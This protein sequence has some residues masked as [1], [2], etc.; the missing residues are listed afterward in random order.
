MAFKTILL[1]GDP[2]RKEGKAGGTITPGQLIK[3]NSS[4]LLIVHAQAGGPAQAWFATEDA[5]QGN[6]I[7]DDYSSGN[8]VQF[9]AARPGDE[10]YAIL[11]TS[12][13]VAIGDLLESAGNGNLR[14]HGGNMESGDCILAVAR[15]AVTTTGAVARIVV[16]II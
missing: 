3:E 11:A 14:K 2:L 12:Q 15:E 7:S 5:L 13:T 8:R 1:K 9:V 6:D 16:E 4:A 10:I